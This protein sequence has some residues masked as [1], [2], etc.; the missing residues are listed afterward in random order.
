MS[1]VHTLCGR[2]AP[3]YIYAYVCVPFKANLFHSLSARLSDF[4]GGWGRFKWP[5]HTKGTR[6]FA[7]AANTFDPPVSY[8]PT[9]FTP[10]SWGALWMGRNS[11]S[12]TT[13]HHQ[14]T[15]FIGGCS[16]TGVCSE[17][18]RAA[19]FNS[20][21]KDSHSLTHR[22]TLPVLSLVLS[23]CNYH[24]NAQSPIVGVIIAG[25]AKLRTGASRHSCVMRK[26]R[27]IWPCAPTFTS[28][29]KVQ[30]ERETSSE[31]RDATNQHIALN[32]R[33]DVPW[34]EGM[35]YC[36]PTG[37]ISS[38]PH[39]QPSHVLRQTSWLVPFSVVS[40]VHILCHRP[41]YTHRDLF[42]IPLLLSHC[43]V[44]VSKSANVWVCEVC[45]LCAS[46]TAELY[47]IRC[48][49]LD[50]D[51]LITIETVRLI[52]CHFSDYRRKYKSLT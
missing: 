13:H 30:G 39:E 2:T 14:R 48:V 9:R 18:F 27:L 37:N 23:R 11:P 42:W 4:G 8:S 6:L 44:P 35:R 21:E 34:S 29:R 33:V 24:Q 52:H 51:I 38:C 16:Q 50:W 12:S 10:A 15:H 43:F 5:S 20:H 32:T 49:F 36:A 3:T 45:L 41:P 1:V 47:Y 46:R 17:G 7:K 19:M 28:G 25:R 26:N 40:M 31:K 22:L